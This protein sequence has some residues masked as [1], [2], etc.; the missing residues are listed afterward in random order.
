MEAPVITA[1][2]DAR[3]RVFDVLDTKGYKDQFSSRFHQLFLEIT[4]KARTC[5]NV[6][7]MQ[8]IKVEADA[9]KVRL[10]NELSRKDE[11]IA[12]D[13][14]KEE[15]EKYNQN[16]TV[17]PEPMPQP[18]IKKRKNIS[19]KSV[20]LAASWQ[21]ET[22]QDVDKYIVALKERILKELDADT[23]INIEF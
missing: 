11:Q 4:E 3:K 2:E 18:K 15:S 14:V 10:L 13:K 20:N 9:L 7:T 22:P 8:N 6:A 16:N 1:I 23:I 17:N 19:I 5:N 12:R 21:I